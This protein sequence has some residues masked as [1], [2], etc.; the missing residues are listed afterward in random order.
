MYAF[1]RWSV[2]DNAQ[3]GDKIVKVFDYETPTYQQA[4]EGSIYIYIVHVCRPSRG[5][6]M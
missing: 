5:A 2:L 3:A 1:E 4:L 6:C